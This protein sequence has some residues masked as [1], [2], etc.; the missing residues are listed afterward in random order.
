MKLDDF[1]KKIEI[2]ILN[3]RHLIVFF[4]FSEKH[5][6]SFQISYLCIIKK[7]KN[8]IYLDIHV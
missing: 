2:D 5:N 4:D 7:K 6:T 8:N 1:K 3:C